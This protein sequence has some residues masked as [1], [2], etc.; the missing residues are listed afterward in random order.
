MYFEK[1]NSELGHFDNMKPQQTAYQLSNEN[2]TFP[3]NKMKN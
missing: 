1:K 3:V 2:C